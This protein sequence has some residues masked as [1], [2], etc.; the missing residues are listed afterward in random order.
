MQLPLLLREATSKAQ[1]PTTGL[2][3][4][5]A[6]AKEPQEERRTLVRQVGQAQEAHAVLARR[7]L[8]G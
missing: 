6:A 3:A 1:G 8:L 5:A 4:G 7:S 2:L